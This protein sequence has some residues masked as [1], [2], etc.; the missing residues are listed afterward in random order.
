MVVAFSN[1]GYM[2]MKF[3]GIYGDKGIF[4]EMATVKASRPSLEYADG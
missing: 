1:T 2:K 3:E 4:V